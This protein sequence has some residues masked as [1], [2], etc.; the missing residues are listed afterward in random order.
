VHGAMSACSFCGVPAL[1]TCLNA[2][3]DC[4]Y[5]DFFKVCAG[6]EG[7]CVKVATSWGCGGRAGER[8]HVTVSCLLL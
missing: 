1:E 3:Y 2:L 7:W 5:K 6:L 4:K 8:G